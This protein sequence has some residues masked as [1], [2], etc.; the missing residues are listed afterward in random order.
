M[1]KINISTLKAHLSESLKKVREG[2][3][4]LVI[5]R[6]TPVAEIIPFN[7][8]KKLEIREPV[9]QFRMPVSDINI[10]TDPVEYL[11]QDRNTR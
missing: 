3:R 5:D 1:E 11:K 4:I 6:N 7:N 9:K 8:Q 2:S 10:E